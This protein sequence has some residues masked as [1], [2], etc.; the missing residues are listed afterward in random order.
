MG[1][2][3]S[4]EFLDGLGATQGPGLTLSYNHTDTWRFSLSA[5]S[6]EV[7]FRLDGAGLAPDGVGEDNSFPVALSVRYAPKPYLS[8]TAFAGAEFD[9]ALR[10]DDSTGTTVETQSYDTAPIAGLAF[11]VL[12]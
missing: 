6:E 3:G 7:R 10:L 1:Y 5:R 4:L 11:R 9:G 2:F 12:F 8:F